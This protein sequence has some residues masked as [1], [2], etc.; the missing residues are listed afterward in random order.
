MMLCDNISFNFSILNF[1]ERFVIT[2]LLLGYYNQSPL[3]RFISLTEKV[4]AKEI[5]TRVGMSSCKSCPTPIDTIPKMRVTH[6][7]PYED[8]SL[9]RRLD[10]SLSN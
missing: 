8:P 4:Y 2:Y 1:L 5:L 6:I 10:G 9:Y 7:T 3:K